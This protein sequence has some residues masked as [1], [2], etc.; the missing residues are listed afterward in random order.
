[1]KNYNKNQSINIKKKN[2]MYIYIY[3]YTHTQW[4]SLVASGMHSSPSGWL[5][6]NHSVYPPPPP[7]PP[8]PPY[9]SI[10]RFSKK[11]LEIWGDNATDIWIYIVH[12]PGIYAVLNVFAANDF[13]TE[14]NDR[15]V[16]TCYICGV[17]L[18]GLEVDI[19]MH[20]FV[21]RPLVHCHNIS[22]YINFTSPPPIVPNPINAHCKIVLHTN[23]SIL[24]LY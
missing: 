9:N 1:M 18:Q 11:A 8:P 21:S 22:F 7:P 14:L 17:S 16:D 20:S 19:T 4:C 23:Y 24:H 15:D 6:L 13:C 5:L 12:P 10:G 3:I 2:C